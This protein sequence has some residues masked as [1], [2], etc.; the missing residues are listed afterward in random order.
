[1]P[2]TKLKK[3]SLLKIAFNFAFFCSVFLFSL[4]FDLLSVQ[5]DIPT[6]ERD[7]LISLYNSTDGANWDDNSDWLGAVGTECD[8]Y[9]VTCDGGGRIMWCRLIL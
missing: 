5:A 4:V 3:S 9:G 6:S 1:M 7:A 8:W 2:K